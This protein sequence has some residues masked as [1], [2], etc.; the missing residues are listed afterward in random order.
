MT[1]PFL[2]EATKNLFSKPSTVQYPNKVKVVEAKPGYRGRIFYDPEKCTGCGLCIKVC[3]PNAITQIVEDIPGGQKIT[4]EFDLTS[5]AFCASC[6]D[7]CSSAAI[8]LTGD[9]HMVAT[10]PEDLIVRG[11]RIKLMSGVLTC[12]EDC[13]FCNICA[14][15]C[16]QDAIVID[17]AEK[18]W[19][20][21]QDK[22]IHC[23]ICIDKCPKKAL[24]F[25]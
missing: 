15:Q 6:Q 23:G 24:S 3:A 18:T 1:F 8:E 7:F 14:V 4:M 9:Y 25:K 10:D 2:R 13:I 5:C 17:R 19:T 11:T 20:V 21:D 16:P 22:C 12:S